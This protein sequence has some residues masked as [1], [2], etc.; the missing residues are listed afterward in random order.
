MKQY[1]SIKSGIEK[2]IALGVLS[3]VV[4]VVAALFSLLIIPVHALIL[5]LCWNYALTALFKFPAIGYP[6][7]ICL[8]VVFRILIR[9]GSEISIK[10]KS[11]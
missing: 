8:V 3:L 11:A 4:V 1:V 10:D 9:S 2:A 6:Q 5:M 7:S